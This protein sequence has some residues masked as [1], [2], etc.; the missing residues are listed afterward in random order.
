MVSFGNLSAQAGEK[1]KGFLAVPGTDFTIPATLICGERPGKTV[2]VSGGVHSCEYVGIEAAIRLAAELA[3]AEIC[4]TVLILHPV[5]RPGF[6]ARTPSIVPWDGCNLNREFPGRADG[7]PT[8]RLAHF[9]VQELY[10]RLDAYI[11]LHCG[12]MFESLTPYIYYAASGD[13]REQ[14]IAREMALC[15]DLPYMVASKAKGGAY[16][17]AG[18]MNI[19]AVLLERGCQGRWSEEEVQAD[20]DDVRRILRYLGVLE[21]APQQNQKPREVVDLVYQLPKSAG[22][23]YPKVTAGEFVKEGQLVGV[24]K[25]YWGQ[26]LSRYH[27]PYD[28]VIL[29]LTHTLWTDGKVEV[30]TIARETE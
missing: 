2:L 12:E 3:P 25:D 27:A 21:S 6:E 22:L 30:F 7:S 9:F 14:R 16:N 1:S 5:N 18:A 13:E 20:L 15:A 10:P 26:E 28:G 8:Q 24:L 4:G 19:P 11:D 17:Y 29:F 23:W